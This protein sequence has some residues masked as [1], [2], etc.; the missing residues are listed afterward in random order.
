LSVDDPAEWMNCGHALRF[1]QRAT[2][3]DL[4]T[5]RRLGRTVYQPPTP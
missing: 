5:T 4:A 1:S 3:E 2:G